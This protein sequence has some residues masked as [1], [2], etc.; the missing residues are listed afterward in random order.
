MDPGQFVEEKEFEST[1][2]LCF[3]FLTTGEPIS[4]ER[5]WLRL[6]WGENL[7]NMVAFLRK[8]KNLL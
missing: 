4:M 6:R 7:T 1:Q 2:S 3:H 5:K 8:K